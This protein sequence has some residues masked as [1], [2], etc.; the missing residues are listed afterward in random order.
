MRKTCD[1]T[2]P[3]VEHWWKPGQGGS[4]GDDPGRQGGAQD[5]GND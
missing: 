5:T 3:G 2:R 4:D 1:Y